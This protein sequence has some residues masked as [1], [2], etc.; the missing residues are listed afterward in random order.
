MDILLIVVLLIFAGFGLHGYLRG[1]VRVLFSLA[2]VFV[3]IGLATALTPYTTHFLQSQTPLYDT[4]KGKCTEYLQSTVKGEIQQ[5]LQS[6]EEISVFG[7]RVP[8][9]IQR[10]FVEDA[11]GQADNLMENTGAYEKIGDFV[12]KQ[13]IQRLAWA[14]SFA[15]I[16]IL[17]IVA[18]HFLDI[19]ARLPVLENINRIGGLAIGLLEGLVVVWIVLL[20]VVLC[21]GTE[22]GRE[23]MDSIE[24]NFLLRVLYENNLIEHLIM[25]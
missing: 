5:K 13:V 6:Q 4:I 11:A 25:G 14:L 18:V 23:M 1:L 16:L 9:E 20:V 10:V 17:L 8:E 7:M 22:F 24:G 2:A 3:S 12:A 21:Q 19:I 15:A